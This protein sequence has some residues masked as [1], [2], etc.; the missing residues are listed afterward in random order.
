MCNVYVKK[1]TEHCLNC[2]RCTDQLDHHSQLINN[3][4]S[5]KNF[6][7]YLRMNVCFCLSIT[8]MMLESAIV[9][10]VSFYNNEVNSYIINKWAIMVL[11][12]MTFLSFIFSL[13]NSIFSCY[14]RWCKLMTR[15]KYRYRE[16]STNNSD[17]SDSEELSE[18]S[19]D[20]EKG[21]E[22][23]RDKK[24]CLMTAY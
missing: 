22:K 17:L 6:S 16:T 8:I 18:T 19:K 5:S 10:T 23:E 14:L 1:E 4:I 15:V 13:Y 3:C 7:N 11:L 24:W 20:K 9:F 2:Q 12:I 21:K